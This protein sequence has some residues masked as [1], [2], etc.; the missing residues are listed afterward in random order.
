VDAPRLARQ[1]VSET[2]E[3][4]AR[5]DLVQEGIL[6]VTELATNAVVH[7]RSDFT[8][9]LSRHGDSVRLSVGD[10]VT[11]PPAA[12]EVDSMVP[13]GKG[14]YLVEALSQSWGHDQID[15]GK[16]VWADLPVR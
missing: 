10:S 14:L 15:G 12:R 13:G 4:W 5:D 2:F 1:F 9:S 7:A 6:V 16:V 8:V 11:H 3:E